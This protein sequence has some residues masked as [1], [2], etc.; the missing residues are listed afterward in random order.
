MKEL[1]ETE[2]KGGKKKMTRVSNEYKMVTLIN[3]KA[4]NF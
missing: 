1:K 2:I 4:F 3:I